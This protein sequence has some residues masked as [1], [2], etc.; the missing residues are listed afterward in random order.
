M[1]YLQ[2]RAADSAKLSQSIADFFLQSIVAHGNGI[3][4]ARALRDDSA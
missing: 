2:R 1:G 3:S 4:E